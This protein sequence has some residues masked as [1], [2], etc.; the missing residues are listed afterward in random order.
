MRASPPS[1]SRFVTAMA[2]A[3][4]ALAALGVV[5]GALQWLAFAATRPD[6]ALREAFAAAG[7]E[8]AA[9][10]ALWWLFDHMG[11]LM[12]G[13]LLSSLLLGVVAWGLL[14]RRCWGWWGFI[15]LLVAGAVFAIAGAC[16]FAAVIDWAN[17]RA[18]LD[19]AAVD[20]LAARLQS[21]MKILMYGGAFAIVAL[22]AAIVWKLC[23]P[24]VR[25]EFR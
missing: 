13:S 4:L 7:P 24:A 3:S 2:W 23:T 14:R 6:Q 11:P 12:A 9:P 5:G 10:P 16:A 1:A 20:P 21:S 15:A 25:A 17:A 18:G 19:L 22:H 8:F